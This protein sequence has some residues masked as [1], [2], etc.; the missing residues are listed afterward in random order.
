MVETSSQ[1]EK[2]E[3]D[4]VPIMSLISHSPVQVACRA[5]SYEATVVMRAVLAVGEGE[6]DHA[7]AE[8]IHD[9]VNENI[10]I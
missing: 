3:S 4:Y 9:T 5:T 2:L 6:I 1:I 10:G 7:K 8:L